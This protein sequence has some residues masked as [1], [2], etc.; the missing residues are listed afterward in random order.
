MNEQDIEKLR[1]LDWKEISA[2]LLVAAMQL[3]VRYR[4]S[5]DSA[6]P[7]GRSLAD[8]VQETI[9]DIWRAPERLNPEVSLHV[10]LAGI[11]RSKLYNLAKCRDEDVIRTDD[12]EAVSARKLELSA[13]EKQALFRRA[14][15]LLSSSPKV[16]GNEDRELVVMAMSEGMFSVKDLAAATGLSEARIYQVTRDIREIYPTIREQLRREECE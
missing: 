6:L 12:L 5:V 2:N 4:W 8:V 1:L 14:M 16:K 3:A 7:N 13:D 9:G 10:Q 15:E 11:V